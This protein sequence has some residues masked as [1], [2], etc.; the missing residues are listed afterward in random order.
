MLRNLRL[1]NK[2]AKFV[3]ESAKKIKDG[4]G[5]VVA[6]PRFGHP[7]FVAAVGMLRM[8]EEEKN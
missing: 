6:C 2:N 8:K 5:R 1:L 3:G 4:E 7:E